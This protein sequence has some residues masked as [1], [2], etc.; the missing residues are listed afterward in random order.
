M[1]LPGKGEYAGKLRTTYQDWH[2]GPRNSGLRM[3]ESGATPVIPQSRKRLAGS[4]AV[5][6]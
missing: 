6:T 2:A 1:D 4:G 3:D 5:A